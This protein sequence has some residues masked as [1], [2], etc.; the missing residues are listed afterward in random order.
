MNQ[1]NWKKNF[2]TMWTGQAISILTSSILQMA[3]I[4]HLTATTQ[5]A[6][7][8]SMAS[9]AG[10]LPNAILG[11]IAGTFV[12]RMN[13]KAIM[14]GAD[15]FIAA[16]SLVL[17]IAALYGDLPVW[18]VLL[19]L[20]I[21][22]VGTAFHT[23]SISAVTPLIVPIEELTKCAGYTQSL[24]TAGYLL[25]TAIAGVLYPI[26]SISTMVALD[27]LGAMVAAATVLITKIPK[28]EA[29]QQTQKPTGFWA[30]LKAGYIAL[31][32]EKGLF[33]LV[34]IAGLFMILYSPINALFPL[35]SFDY[36]AGTSIH[37][38]IAEITFSVGMLIGGVLLGKW[39]G[40]KDRGLGIA[41]SIALMGVPIALSGLLPSNGFWIFAFLCII[42]GLSCPFYNGP[43]I[44]LLQE[45]I[46]PEYLGRVFGLYGSI[47]S[48]AM[49][50]GLFI[51]GIFADSVGVSTWFL[52]TGILIVLTALLCFII[53]SI[54]EIDKKITLPANK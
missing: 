24:Q 39:G 45:R 31:K 8:L 48:F 22:S 30:D 25:G 34:W 50:I 14:I 11:I 53:P 42:M 49:P 23:P 18:L 20:A 28:T 2:Y 9:L 19:V 27:V 13:R 40:L 3:L 41:F 44:A 12:D 46:S 26:C 54:R 15:L 43:V 33:A 5:S 37:A 29:A 7:V 47:A 6:L 17:T 16:V 52:I 1:E 21:R 32:Q 36:F 4:W 38:A 35:M 51:S 10:F